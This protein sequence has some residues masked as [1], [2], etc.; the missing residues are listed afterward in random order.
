MTRW[1]L[2]FMASGWKDRYY[3]FHT[4]TFTLYATDMFRER[5]P[6][7]RLISYTSHK[8]ISYQYVCSDREMHTRS[9]EHMHPPTQAAKLK[10][11]RTKS[12]RVGGKINIIAT[13]KCIRG[14]MS[15]C[16]RRHKRRTYKIS[17]HWCWH[18]C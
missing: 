6:E 4:N 10:H 15:V 1:I 11:L 12:Q 13:G 16:I 2:E 3:F 17:F 9:D 18:E 14:R 7:N 5:S 8:N